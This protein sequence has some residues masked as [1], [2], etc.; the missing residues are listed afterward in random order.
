[1][2]IG[3][4]VGIGIVVIGLSEVITL[5]IDWGRLDFGDL[6]KGA[7]LRRVSIAALTITLGSLMTLTSLVIGYLSLPLRRPNQVE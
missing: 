3:L 4:L 1:M 2:E 6:E 5:I 7:Y